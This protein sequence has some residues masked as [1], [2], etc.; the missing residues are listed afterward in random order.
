MVSGQQLTALVDDMFHAKDPRSP[1]L[2]FPHQYAP[3][4]QARRRASGWALYDAVGVNRGD[5]AASARQTERNFSFFGAPHHAVTRTPTS[6]GS[7]GVLDTGLYVQTFLLAAAALGL[8]AIAQA[9]PA[10]R[11]ALLHRRLGISEDQ[12]VVC[13]IAFGYADP[14]HPANAFRTERTPV[15]A[16]V[17]FHA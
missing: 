15:D 10:S 6:L 12:A 13:S 4:H 3:Q 14:D 1:D 17:R 5:R 2:P 16:L 11:S 8:G 9:A 7:Y